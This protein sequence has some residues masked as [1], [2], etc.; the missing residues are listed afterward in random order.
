M[1]SILKLVERIIAKSMSNKV[2]N[3]GI[4]RMFTHSPVHHDLAATL[5]DTS[6]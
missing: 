3:N 5:M 2:T 1:F 4:S 6:G